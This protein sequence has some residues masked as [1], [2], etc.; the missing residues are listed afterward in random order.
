VV[1][2]MDFGIAKLESSNMTASGTVLGTPYYMSPEQVRGMRVDSRSDIFALGAILYELFVYEKAFSGDM[3][4]VFYKIVHEN[5]IPLSEYLELDARP[6]QEMVDLCLQKDKANRLQTAGELADLLRQAVEFYRTSGATISGL[7]TVLAERPSDFHLA[8]APTAVGTSAKKRTSEFI[9]P[10]VPSSA[11]YQ[12]PLPTALPPGTRVP[13]TASLSSSR[14]IL[15][16]LIGLLFLLG[17]G[18]VGAYVLFF[19]TPPVIPGGKTSAAYDEKLKQAKALHQQEKYD[20]AIPI[21]EQLEKENPGD[22]EVHYLL[23]AADVKVGQHQKALAEFQTAVELNPKQDKAWQQIGF[24]LLNRS[25]WKGAENAFRRALEVDPNSGPTWDGLAQTYLVSQQTDKAEEAYKR[26]LQIE[27]QNVQAVYNL[28][29]IVMARKDF[30][31]AGGYF[32]QAI[33]INPNYAEAH[34]N[35]GAIYLE[36]GKV[37]AS[38]AENEKAVQIKPMLSSAHYSL[39]LAYEQKHD[40][41]NAGMHLQKYLEITGDEDP[42][43]KK[44]VDQYQH[45]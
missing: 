37:D 39:Y 6:L 36:E 32:R 2:I 29:Q 19:R 26:L 34:N 18:A 31:T 25:D 11:S 41:K 40:F 13:S 24:I 43:L 7:K 1:K 20:Q 42:V 17:V 45:S 12:A 8:P 38:I 23:G 28:G 30:T 3:A 9:S 15:L 35:L 33:Q 44:K 16:V 22:P 14:S 4:A 5:P 21:Y 27:P 10:T